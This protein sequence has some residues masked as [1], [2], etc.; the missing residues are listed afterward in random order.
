M[1]DILN[2]SSAKALLVVSTVMG[3]MVALQGVSSADAVSDAFTSLGTSATTNIGLGVA[4]IVT[5][6]TLGFGIGFLVKL[7]KKARSAV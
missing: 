5:C 3:A 2:T 7:A 4:L 6:L 1:K